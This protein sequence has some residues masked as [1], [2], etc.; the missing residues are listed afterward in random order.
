[1]NCHLANEIFV[2]GD[3]L[4][5]HLIAFVCPN[6]DAIQDL[7]KKIGFKE[8]NLE[9]ILKAKEVKEAVL[10]ELTQVGKEGKLVGFELVRNIY[11]EN[12]SFLNKGIL[13]TTLKIK[14]HESRIN[15]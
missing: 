8:T 9:I 2:Y 3:S 4:Q 13:T 15:Y 6:M 5:S 7:C 10:N 1:M 14:R 12:G 11:L